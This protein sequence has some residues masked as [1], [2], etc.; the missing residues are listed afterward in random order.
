MTGPYRFTSMGCEVIV[1]GAEPAELRAVEALF[2]ERDLL[3]SRFRPESELSL[4]NGTSGRFVRV[5]SAFAAAIEM[6]LVAAEATEGLVDPTLG[7]AIEAA[8][9]DR[10][11]EELAPDPRPARSAPVGSWQS[12]RIAGRLLERPEGL[13][14]DLNGVVKSL[15]VDDAIALLAGRGFVAAGG[16]LATRGPLDTELPGGESVRLVAGAL[17]TSGSG[18][19]RWLRAGRTQHHLIDPST[20]SPADSP[21]EQVTVAGKT[22]FAADVSAKAA[23]LLGESGPAWLDRRRLPGRFLSSDGD[24]V[25]NESWR[26]SLGREPACI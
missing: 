18:R 9:Y 10:D 6:A 21:W 26:R 22:C 24:V 23:F 17:A 16:D 3:F 20:G 25:T 8:G 5:S 14:L 19:R 1:G 4:V 15:A 2:Q 11:F 13:R 7:A 12:V